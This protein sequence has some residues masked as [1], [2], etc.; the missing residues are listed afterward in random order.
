MPDRPPDDRGPEPTGPTRSQGAG[1]LVQTSVDRVHLGQYAG[2]ELTA[3][4]EHRV[5]RLALGQR[6]HGSI[7][8]GRRRGLTLQVTSPGGANGGERYDVAMPRPADPWPRFA[9]RVL[10]VAGA[11]WLV[12]R[13][14]RAA[15]RRRASDTAGW[16]P[17]GAAR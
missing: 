11:S 16:D 5:L 6:W 15:Q 7:A 2:H 3:D 17:E 14:A 12:I 4:V 10:A 1:A 8:L 9:R 13:L